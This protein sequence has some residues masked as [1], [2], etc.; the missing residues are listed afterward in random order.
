MLALTF[1]AVL[2]SGCNSAPTR[3]PDFAN[4]RPPVPRLSQPT[5]GAIYASHSD[6]PL[7]E[8]L[9]ARRVGDILTVT[10][11]E[12]TNAQKSA[13]TALDKS[14][15]VS[16]A[17]PTIL[18]APV[19][20]GAPSLLPLAAI[21]PNT[22]ETRLES[23]H[24]FDGEAESSQSNR[25]SG[26]ITVSVAEVLPNGNLVIQGEKLYTL[27]QG[28][29]HIRFSGIVRPYDI[30]ASN[31]VVSTKVADARIV[32]AGEG[33]TNDTNVIG[34]LARFFVSAVFPF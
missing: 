2:L 18:G 22:L 14:T 9:R 19:A 6:M 32:Y 27:N 25:L 15:N 21:S 12:R 23:E 5:A 7:F 34:W 4:V 28:H 16:V 31:T 13:D 26:D 30:D 24:A 8:D 11:I 29:E 1:G 20:F 3:D 10:L 17:N 33:A